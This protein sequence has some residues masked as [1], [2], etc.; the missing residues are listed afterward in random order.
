MQPI[1]ITI[2]KQPQAK[3]PQ[4]IEK[5]ILRL[6][7][8]AIKDFNLIEDGDRVMVAV[9]GGKD[10]YTL[11]NILRI[12]QRKAPVRFDLLAV[13]VHPGWDNYP[14]HIIED[15]LRRESYEY[16]MERTQMRQVI[17]EK[18]DPGA[19]LCS[20]CARLRRGVLYR[21]AKERGANKVAL[22]HHS[23]D[24]IETLLMSVFFQGEIR[25]M[26][27]R[28]LSDDGEHVVIRPL[29]YVSEEYTR[30]YSLQLGFPVVCCGCPICGDTTLQRP[31][32]KALLKEL[33][34]Q[35]P[36]LKRSMVAAL[37]N[38]NLGHL[39]DR[40]YLALGTGKRPP[41]REE[42]SWVPRLEA[43]PPQEGASVNSSESFVS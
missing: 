16:H 6:V 18:I 2:K 42:E 21:L 38:V 43:D 7:G 10:S 35:N 20:M 33:E 28:L 12:I 1:Q 22:G 39:M 19:T 24:L 27:P 9:S 32:I 11:L 15:Y 29:C 13:N 36:R 14:T 34:A 17:E 25:S 40:R 3:S 37:A 31:K 30:R 41:R 23:D 4:A 8:S 26:P 5:S